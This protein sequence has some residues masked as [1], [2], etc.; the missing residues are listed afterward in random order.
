MSV[1]RWLGCALLID[2][3]VVLS[4]P[5]DDPVLYTVADGRA[6]ILCIREAVVRKPHLPFPIGRL[7]LVVAPCVIPELHAGD[8]TTDTRP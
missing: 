6:D 1:E 3:P 7:L 8:R 5:A 2:R 4:D